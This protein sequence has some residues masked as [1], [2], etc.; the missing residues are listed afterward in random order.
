MRPRHDQI[1]SLKVARPRAGSLRLTGVGRLAVS[2]FW[3][4]P[5]AFP[6]SSILNILD[7]FFL[8]VY[9]VLPIL[10][11][12]NTY[13]AKQFPMIFFGN[14]DSSGQEYNITRILNAQNFDLDLEAYDGYSKLY[15]SI[16]FALNYGLNFVVLAITLTHVALF[17]GKY[18]SSFL[19][20]F[21]PVNYEAVPH[22]W[23][24]TILI[25]VLR[26]ALWVCEGFDKQFQLP[27]WGILLA[28]GMALF[29]TLPIRI[30]I[31]TTNNTPGLNVITEL[32][33]GFIY[34]GNPLAKVSFKTYGYISM[35]QA[36]SFT[37]DFKLGHYLKIPMKL[38]FL[39]QLVGTII[40]SS[41]YF[42]TAWWQITSNPNI[43]NRMFG[44]PRIYHH[45][46]WFFLIGLLAPMPAWYL[47]CRF[48][49]KKWIKHIKSLHRGS[50]GILPASVLNYTSWGVVG[51]FFNIY[52]YK[53]FKG[54]WAWYNYVLSAALDARVAFMGALLYF[55]FQ[56]IQLSGPEW[57]GPTNDD[58]CKLATCP[59][60]PL[61][62]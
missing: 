61:G 15:L 53:R 12:S 58:D 14:F 25:I 35:V 46:N 50:T 36:I 28:C 52:V 32:V 45:L 7:G 20:I 1:W 48:P 4:S 54:W 33:I 38:M 62:T 10:Y 59:I 42:A 9:V 51:I 26:L 16:F 18:I 8:I 13:E 60:S 17:H 6:G 39:V 47:L 5:L 3:G 21:S 55:A 57:W 56:S 30:M 27:W 19:S 22:W 2:S 29:F 11:Y 43:C 40:G 31:A 41:V 44:K 49:D 37:S 24:H 23:F 34:P